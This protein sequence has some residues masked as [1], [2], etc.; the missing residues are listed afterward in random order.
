MRSFLFLAAL[1][2]CAA[3]VTQAPSDACGA[4]D[5]AWLV[6]EPESL[7]AAMIFEDTTRF[8]GPED[9][10]TMDYSADRLNIVTGADGRIIRVYC[11]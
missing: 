6:G 11:G 10:V 7:L 1:A 9:A 5:L 3:P 4:R 8:I 2:G